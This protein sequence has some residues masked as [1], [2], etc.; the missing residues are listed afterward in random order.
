MAEAGR[1]LRADAE[2][3]RRALLDAAEAV[4]SERGFDVSV[5][6]IAQ[7]AG[8]GHGT[9][10]R[11]F[12]TK[13]HLIAAIVVDR[14]AGASAR[15]RALLD[16]PDPAEGMFEWLAD[17]VGTKQSD[18]WLFEALADSFL[19]NR[20]IRAAHTEMVTALDALLRRAQEAGAVRP[21]VGAVDV[22]MLIKGVCEAIGPFQQLDPQIGQRQLDLMRA[23]LS[24]SPGARPLRGRTPTL[25]DLE[26]AFPATDPSSQDPALGKAGV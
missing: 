13:D 1:P 2:R 5:A 24:V 17:M 11:R 23:A 26:R 22:L 8:V 7:R 3:N 19:A 14:M 9:V 21:D 6:E 25:D 18:R 12:P 16:A 4:F 20:D 15:C 10:F